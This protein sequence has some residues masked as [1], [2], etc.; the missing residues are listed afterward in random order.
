MARKWQT[1][2]A[3]TDDELIDVFD[4]EAEHTVLGLNFYRDELMRRALERATNAALAE[5]KAAREE[6]S[7][8]R[9]LAK[10]NMV[11]AMVA[12]VV[13]IATS[14]VQIVVAG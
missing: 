7:A 4:S 3:M 8:S 1:L 5:A 2:Q 6:A 14:V 11:V 10:W 12:V 13:A 9:K